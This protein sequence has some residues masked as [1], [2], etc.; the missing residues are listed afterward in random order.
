MRNRYFFHQ[1]W[2]FRLANA[3]PLEQALAA[4]RDREGR[5]PTDRLYDD[6]DWEQVTLP[7]TFNGEDLF[8]TPIEDGGSGQK[9]TCAFYRNRLTVPSVHRDKRVVMTLEGV[10]QTCYL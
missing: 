7:H 4:C 6:A 9:R 10:R 2:R 8:A 1:N 3:F 5:S